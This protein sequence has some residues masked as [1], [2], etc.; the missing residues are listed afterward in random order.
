M[1]E[2]KFRAKSIET[3][4]WVYGSLVCQ[5]GLTI[6]SKYYIATSNEGDVLFTE[7]TRDTVCQYTGL[8]DKNDVEIYEGDLLSFGP[9]S[10][11]HTVVWNLD[12]AVFEISDWPL[13]ESVYAAEIIGNIYE[14]PELLEPTTNG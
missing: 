3:G 13:H 12:K 8:K 2:I 11:A 1:R 7:V 4:E 6:F 14:N 5:T 10:H 9:D